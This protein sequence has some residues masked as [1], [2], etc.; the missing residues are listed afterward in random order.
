MKEMYE[1]EQN[2]PENREPNRADIEY[3][4]L[5]TATNL[6]KDFWNEVDPDGVG[7]RIAKSPIESLLG[8]QTK[9]RDRTVLQEVEDQKYRL[10]IYSNA[11]VNL[12][13]EKAVAFLKSR[14]LI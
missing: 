4:D 8:E 1:G 10:V 5:V 6:L 11:T 7:R 3:N 9:G 12:L 14:G 2:T 13:S